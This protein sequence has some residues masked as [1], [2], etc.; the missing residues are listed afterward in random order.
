MA[1]LTLST[2]GSPQRVVVNHI[3]RDDNRVV[4]MIA[5]RGHN[6]HMDLT[7]FI[8]PPV[9]IVSLVEEEQ[10]DPSTAS[11]TPVLVKPEVPFDPSGV[12]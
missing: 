6:M 5:K 2:V 7:N 12:G 4:D 1:A 3:V 11:A 8:V 10:R 9:D